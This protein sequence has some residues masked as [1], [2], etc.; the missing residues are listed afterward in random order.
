M[1]ML[2]SVACAAAWLVFKVVTGHPASAIGDAMDAF[3]LVTLVRGI[4]LHL[5][6]VK[7]PH[8]DTKLSESSM[9]VRAW[10][11]VVFLAAL[12]AVSLPLVMFFFITVPAFLILLV[13]LGVDISALKKARGGKDPW[14]RGVSGDGR[15]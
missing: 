13:E 4:V 3:A 11:G 15:P 9:K 12:A 2:I 6:L 7:L 10:Q 8:S 14:P 5:G 1:S